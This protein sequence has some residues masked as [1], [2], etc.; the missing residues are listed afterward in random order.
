MNNHFNG[1]KLFI[2]NEQTIK[3]SLLKHTPRQ[4]TY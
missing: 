2:K 3:N 1:R 4:S